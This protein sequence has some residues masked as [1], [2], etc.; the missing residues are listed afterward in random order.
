M[1]FATK[2]K[3]IENLIYTLLKSI[4]AQ[5]HGQLAIEHRDL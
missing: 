5:R 3:G 4:L 1:V 2:A